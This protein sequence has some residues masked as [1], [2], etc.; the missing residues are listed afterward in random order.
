MSGRTHSSMTVLDAN[1]EVNPSIKI[2]YLFENIL[3]SKF[4]G[5]VFVLCCQCD[6]IAFV[7]I[8]RV[9]L[10]ISCNSLIV[11]FISKVADTIH[12]LFL[13]KVFNLLFSFFS[14]IPFEKNDFCEKKRCG[15]LL[16]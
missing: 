15:I 7:K 2:K 4:G 1:L 9:N 3:Q 13:S 5:T 11:V 14:W 12:R 10:A 8:I 6:R 16:C